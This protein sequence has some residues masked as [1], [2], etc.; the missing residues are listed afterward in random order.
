MECQTIFSKRGN[1]WGTLT[2]PLKLLQGSWLPSVPRKS[3]YFDL[4]YT[5]NPKGRWFKSTPG[6]HL[7][8]LRDYWNS[9]QFPFTGWLRFRSGHTP[10]NPSH[11]HQDEPK[12]EQ[13]P[14]TGCYDST[15]SYARAFICALLCARKGIALDCRNQVKGS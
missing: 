15:T 1:N 9:P 5:H 12:R 13:Q 6:N 11:K 4:G 10:K 2:V 14:N 3:L 8:I 7:A